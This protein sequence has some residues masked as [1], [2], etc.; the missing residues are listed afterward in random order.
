MCFYCFHKKI[1]L[2]LHN[3]NIRRHKFEKFPCLISISDDLHIDNHAL[4]GEHLKNVHENMEVRFSDLLMM[5]IPAWVTN[6]FEINA[7]DVDITLQ[8]TV[9]LQSDGIFQAKFNDG[10]H[11]VWKTNDTAKKNSTTVG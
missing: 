5:A 8:E 11:N 4:Y 10:Q 6:P 1:K 7:V 3:I 9:E 2:Q